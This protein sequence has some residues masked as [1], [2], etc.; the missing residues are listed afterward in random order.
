MQPA[1]NPYVQS[2]HTVTGHSTINSYAS[3]YDQDP[4]GYDYQQ[5]SYIY[6][7]PY[8]GYDTPTSPV[9]YHSPSTRGP[10]HSMPASSGFVPLNQPSTFGAP[11]LTSE[12]SAFLPVSHTP[13][14]YNA[15]FQSP[16][17]AYPPLSSTPAPNSS[18]LSQTTFQG[19][20][21]NFGYA[22]YGV[23]ASI[24]APSQSYIP[25]PPQPTQTP[26]HYPVTS[27]V[28][29]NPAATLN[30][31]APRPLP[32]QP[33]VIYAQ[34]QV[35]SPVS[36]PVNSFTPP[37]NMIAFPSQESPYPPPPP[38]PSNGVVNAGTMSN[39]QVLVPPPPPPP[40]NVGQSRR[41]MSLPQ[42]PV[43][44]QPLP[45]PPPPPPVTD[46]YSSNVPLVPP[47][48]PPPLLNASHS[49]GR[50]SPG[51]LPNPPSLV[52]DYGQWAQPGIS[53]TLNAAQT[54]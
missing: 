15:P 30:G 44:Q 43:Y 8:Q 17:Q 2:S 51:A 1:P 6:Q 7:P 11:S 13:A 14:P 54:Y 5:P 9:N 18:Y 46:Y 26:P 40:L 12:P 49:I 42:P 45:P 3:Y 52:N 32:Q 10:R 48:P 34:N 35:Q 29:D 22:S 39:G 24:S 38:P 23:P 36:Q 27:P 21:Q 47:P 25:P 4:Y 31:H 37:Q 33:Q 53:Q 19:S 28:Q 41:R 20:P 16:V 50:H